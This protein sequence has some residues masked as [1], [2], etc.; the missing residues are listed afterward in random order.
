M[1]VGIINMEKRIVICP[2][3]D[4]EQRVPVDKNVV[5]C[6]KCGFAFNVDTDDR[7]PHEF[8]HNPDSGHKF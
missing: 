8:W 3:C 7:H 1:R 2:K 4:K 5:R 6:K